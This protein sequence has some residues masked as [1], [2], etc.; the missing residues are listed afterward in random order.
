MEMDNSNQTSIHQR[1]I[2]SWLIGP[3]VATDRLVSNCK[4]IPRPSITHYER[5]LSVALSA[6]A[7]MHSVGHDYADLDVRSD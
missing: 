3:R 4:I 6:S 7:F 5:S 2:R 1:N